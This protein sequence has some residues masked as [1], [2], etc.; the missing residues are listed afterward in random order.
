MSESADATL[1]RTALDDE[2]VALGARMVPFGGFEMPVAVRGHPQANTTRCGTAPGCSTSRT[3]RSTSCAATASRNGRTA[4][5]VNEVATMKPLQ[6]RYNIFTNP[7]RR[8]PRRRAV[9]PLARSLAARR[10]RRQ[11][12]EDVAVPR[13]PPNR[14][15]GV[16]LTNRHGSRALIAVQGPRAVEIVAPLCDVDRRRDEV[17]FLRRG[18]GRRRP[19]DHRAHRLHRRGRLRAVR[20][21]RG[22]RAAVARCCSNAA[23]RSARARGARRAR[24]AAARSR[25]AA[26]RARARR[27]HLAAR[28]RSGL[29]REVSQAGLRRQGRARRRS[30]MPTTYDRIAGVVLEGRVPAR[31]GYPVF[32]GTA[33]ASARCAALRSRRRSATATSRPCSSKR[34][35]PRWYE[36]RVEI[37]GARTPRPSSRFPFTA[38]RLYVRRLD[39]WQ[40]EG[41][42]TAKNTSGLR[43][44]ATSRPSASPTT[45]RI[46]SA[47]S[48]TSSLPRVG[49]RSPSTPRSASSNR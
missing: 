31:A 3:W 9:L 21:R 42:S 49:Q 19:G 13:A 43:S 26:L 12:R 14:S 25:H 39:Q 8:L 32:L 27:R 34:M 10:Q 33:S 11:R 30:A 15:C 37:R 6:A 22:C 5:T 24:H 23:R 44:T 38:G 7:A 35:R 18:P 47:T 48:S 28:R 36:A 4:L 2:H 46:R 16:R 41:F 20:R 40:P 29:G 1:R 45:R 17:L